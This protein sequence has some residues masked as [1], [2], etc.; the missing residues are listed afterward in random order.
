[1]SRIEMIRCYNTPKGVLYNIEKE[2]FQTI[3]V[4]DI[5]WMYPDNREFILKSKRI[6]K[7]QNCYTSKKKARAIFYLRYGYMPEV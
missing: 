4:K 6:L 2:Q 7:A 1:M 5:D 3:K